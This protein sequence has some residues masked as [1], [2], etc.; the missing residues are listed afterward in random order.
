MLFIHLSLIHLQEFQENFIYF[1]VLGY[2]EVKINLIHF[3]KI[4]STWEVVSWVKV[5]NRL[6]RVILYH[7]VNAPVII[8][9]RLL[10]LSYITW[11]QLWW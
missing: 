8:T 2:G 6:L 10:F 9:H 11:S 4:F 5:F 1:V 3:T 7:Q